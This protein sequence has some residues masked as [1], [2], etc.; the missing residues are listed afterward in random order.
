[1]VVSTG[2]E[3]LLPLGEGD[4]GVE[5]QAPVSR[6]GVVAHT[7]RVKEGLV[8]RARGCGDFEGDGSHGGS[9]RL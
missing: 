6:V 2:F 5:D 4:R 8:D 3:I 7:E 1:M 9:W